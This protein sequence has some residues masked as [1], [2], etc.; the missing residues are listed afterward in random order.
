MWRINKFFSG[1]KLGTPC[2]TTGPFDF[3]KKQ[4]KLCEIS[5][6]IRTV[7]KCMKSLK[8]DSRF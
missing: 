6:L 2:T 8:I 1:G 5:D 4:L 3:K 7:P